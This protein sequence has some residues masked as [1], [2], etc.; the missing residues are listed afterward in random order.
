[1]DYTLFQCLDENTILVPEGC[2]WGGLNDQMAIGRPQAM[3]KYLT[4]YDRI[5]EILDRLSPYY[6]PEPAL[7]ENVK[8]QGLE[9]FRFPF[10]YRLINGKLYHHA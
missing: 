1:M 6:G 10:R 5:Y 2:D 3:S 7:L 8:S 4:L 9:V